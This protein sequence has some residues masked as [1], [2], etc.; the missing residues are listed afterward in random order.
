MFI[1]GA[2]PSEAMALCQ[3]GNAQDGRLLEA[4]FA[5]FDADGD[6]LITQEELKNALV[7]AW[8]A[9][10][11]TDE[12]VKKYFEQGDTNKDGQLDRDEFKALFFRVRDAEKAV[13]QE[14]SAKL[15]T[16][17]LAE[18]KAGG[19]G[20]DGH[21]APDIVV[22]NKQEEEE[23]GG[24]C[25]CFGSK[26]AEEAPA[27]AETKPEAQVELPPSRTVAPGEHDPNVQPPG[28][29]YMKNGVWLDNDGNEVKP[30]GAAPAPA[31]EAAA[32]A[33]AAGEAAAGSSDVA[34][35]DV[36]VTAAVAE[37]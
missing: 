19:G 5:R 29:S 4:M 20:N 17:K 33:P 18:K 2:G 16:A 31:P 15:Q 3:G 13:A 25:C 10:E 32:A 14:E 27:P 6:G 28:A 34:L 1:T 35:A 8:K 37:K 11:P 7:D 36:T 21:N 9:A 26:K 12:D 24:G 22:S 23:K 30:G